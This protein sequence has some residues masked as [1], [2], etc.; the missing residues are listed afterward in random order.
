[1]FVVAS[2]FD[3]EPYSIPNLDGNNSFATYVAEKEETALREVM[4]NVMYDDFIAGIVDAWVQK[5][6]PNGY[7]IGAQAAV[8]N[9]VWESLT[10]DNVAIVV[11]GVNW[12]K[13]ETD[14]KWLVLKNGGVYSTSGRW[15]G[16]KKLLIPYIYSYWVGDAYDTNS[17]I[18]VVKAKAEN[19]TPISPKRRIVRA[20]NEY[21]RMV[22]DTYRWGYNTVNS[23]YGFVNANSDLYPD[24]V[25]T[26][27]KRMNIFGL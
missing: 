4:G 2:D 8:G 23:L 5:V 22:G 13:V 14:N 10:A 25:F 21:V 9:D 12:H 27:P 3:I 18:G 7:D 19:A 16:M 6:T 1:M 24:F 15:V 11:E 17:G 26:Y 20:W